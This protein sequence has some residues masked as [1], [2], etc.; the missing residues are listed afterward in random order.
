M[1]LVNTTRL[2]AGYTMATDK[3]GREWLVVVAKGTYGIPVHPEREPA[4]LDAQVPLVMTDVFTGEPGASALLYEHDF[5]PV[6]PRCDVL[7]HGSC[8]APG[9]RQASQVNVAL[10]VG[11]LVK[12]FKVVGPRTYKS[13]LMSSASTAPQPFTVLPITYNQ[14]FGGVDRTHQDPAEYQ[15]YPLNPAGVGFHPK[16]AATKLHGRPLPIT[17]ELGDPVRKPQGRYRP[18]AFG[19]IGRAWQ[20]RLRWA[21]TYDQKWLDQQPIHRT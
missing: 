13:G 7:L 6:K 4:L 3:S 11:A 16:T 19:P 9:G 1:E 12:G 20:Q 10:K 2:V 8:H 15:W 14:A 5:A 18:M 21:G 17:E